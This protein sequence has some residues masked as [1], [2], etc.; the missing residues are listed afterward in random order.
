[1]ETEVLQQKLFQKIKLILPQQESMVTKVASLLEISTDSAYRRIRGE[2]EM[3][4]EELRKLAVSFKFSLDELFHIQTDGFLFNGRI[5][6]SSDFTYEDWLQLCIQHTGIIQKFQPNHISYLAK[7]IPFFYYFLYPEIAAFKSYFFMKSILD[8]ESYRKKRFSLTDDYSHFS[9]NWKKLS[10]DFAAIPST[11]IWSMENIT[12]TIHQIEFYR[13]TEFISV[14]DAQILFEKLIEIMNHVE[15]QAENGVKLS[16]TQNPSTSKVPYKMYMN[17]LIMGDN[18]L[19]VQL[20]D[21]QLTYLNHSVINFITTRDT[22][23][24]DYMRVTF[25]NLTQKSTLLSGA[26][27]KDRVMFFNKVRSKLKKAMTSN[28]S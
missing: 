21:T 6:N 14:D 18:M 28:H 25:N 24:N 12:S 27:E 11:E 4:I 13:D 8:Y 23:F 22:A 19:I 17:E 10:D 7:E 9:A 15:K 2:K 5:T 20:G 26:N 1:M 3:T 16:V